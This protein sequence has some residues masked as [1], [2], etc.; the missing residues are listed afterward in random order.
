M[1][2]YVVKDKATKDINIYSE[3]NH[4]TI[5]LIGLVAFGHDFETLTK[6]SYFED[7][8]GIMAA[9]VDKRIKVPKF[10][11]PLVFNDHVLF[12]EVIQKLKQVPTDI[13]HQRRDK[14]TTDREEVITCLVFGKQ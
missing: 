9:C 2:A 14:A 8:L 3:F 4:L 12:T 13:L 10:M 6:G 5:D 11:W 1:W 7:A